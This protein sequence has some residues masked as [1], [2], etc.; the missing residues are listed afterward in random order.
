VGDRVDEHMVD[1]DAYKPVGKDG[2]HLGVFLEIGEISVMLMLALIF[3]YYII[4]I[5]LMLFMSI[6]RICDVNGGSG[7]GSGILLRLHS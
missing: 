3:V 1:F 4:Y 2:S 6:K 5:L 7:S